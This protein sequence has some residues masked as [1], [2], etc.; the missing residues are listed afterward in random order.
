MATVLV[1]RLAVIV[2]RPEQPWEGETVVGRSEAAGGAVGVG[3]LA[4]AARGQ[5][6]T[7]SPGS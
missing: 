3:R 4:V 6:E 2:T 1:P 5:R 7:R